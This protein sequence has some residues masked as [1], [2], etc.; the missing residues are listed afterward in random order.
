MDDGPLHLEFVTKGPCWV[1]ARVDGERVLAK[2]LQ[3]GE[4][5]TLQMRDEVVLRIGEP[6]ALSMSINGRAT[7]PI[8][9]PGQP[10]T[11][12]ITKDNFQDLL[13]S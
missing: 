12:R 5:H 7:R 10:L 4:R 6:G 3:P 11:V 9:K 1:S 8:G 13:G 2:L